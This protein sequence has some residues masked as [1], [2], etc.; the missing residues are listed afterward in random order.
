MPA[1]N[2][3]VTVAFKTS[4]PTHINV[5]NWLQSQDES[6]SELIRDAVIAAYEFRSIEQAADVPSDKKVRALLKSNAELRKLLSLNETIASVALSAS[7]SA[8]QPSAP[9]EPVIAVGVRKSSESMKPGVDDFDDGEES[10]C[11]VDID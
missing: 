3:T 11:V 4:N 7:P 2:S 8:L 10:K 6:A 1:S 5:Y 9:T